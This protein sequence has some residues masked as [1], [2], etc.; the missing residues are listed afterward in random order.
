MNSRDILVNSP[1]SAKHPDTLFLNFETRDATSSSKRLILRPAYPVPFLVCYS[2]QARVSLSRICNHSSLHCTAPPHRKKHCN[3]QL[4]W[5]QNTLQRCILDSNQDPGTSCDSAAKRLAS[6][7]GEE[8]LDFPF[9]TPLGLR[10]EV[11]RPRPLI[12]Q[13]HPSSQLLLLD[14]VTS[15][16][17][18]F[19]S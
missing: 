14:P 15:L 17:Y 11:T 6:S 10:K 12:Q 1:K 9:R 2:P 8:I 16:Q 5:S 3:A 4:R 7:T 13:G 18:S 19:R